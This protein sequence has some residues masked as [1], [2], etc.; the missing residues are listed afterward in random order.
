MDHE[1]FEEVGSVKTAVDKTPA[2]KIRRKVKKAA[3]KEPAPP[4]KTEANAEPEPVPPKL[5]RPKKH[6]KKDKSND[7]REKLVCSPDRPAPAPRRVVASVRQ[8]CNLEWEPSRAEYTLNQPIPID[9]LRQYTAEWTVN[10]ELHGVALVVKPSAVDVYKYPVFEVTL[11]GTCFPHPTNAYEK[12]W[13]RA[14]GVQDE[15]GAQILVFD[16]MCNC[17]AFIDLFFK[18]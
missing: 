3:K 5:S 10:D 8:R 7:R 17:I 2:P 4:T 14:T 1:L 12:L 13:I 9:K 16:E 6:R 18:K 15:D 11:N